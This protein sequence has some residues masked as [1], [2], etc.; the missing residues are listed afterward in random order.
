MIA[1]MGRTRFIMCAV[2]ILVLCAALSLPRKGNG[3]EVM[4]FVDK[5][6]P[7]GEKEFAEMSA[8]PGIRAY[9]LDV[10]KGR[11]ISE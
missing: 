5:R 8:N 9:L 11:A 4:V 3:V 7:A 1:R 2:L 6:Q 10:K